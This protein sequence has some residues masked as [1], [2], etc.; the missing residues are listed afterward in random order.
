MG[1]APGVSLAQD[2]DAARIK[3]LEAE[4]ANLRLMV[5]TLESLVRTAPGTAFAQERSAAVP[6]DLGPRVVILETQIG[7]LTHQVEQIGQK[8]SALQA[9]LEAKIDAAPPPAAVGALTNQIEQMGQ[10]VSALEAK[11]KAKLDAASEP[12]APAGLGDKVDALG[13]KVSALEAQLNAAPEPAAPAGLGDQVDALGKKMRALET[14]LETT[15]KPAA[16]ESLTGQIAEL[17]KKMHTLETRL[18]AMPKAASAP[19]HAMPAPQA[20]VPKDVAPED[21]PVAAVTPAPRPTIMPE[22]AKQEAAGPEPAEPE[23][24]APEPAPVMPK[25]LTSQSA[26]TF[27]PTKP[28]WYGPRPGEADGGSPQSITPPATTGALSQSFA[29]LP[30]ENAQALY[31]QGYGDFLQRNYPAAEK[32]FSKLVKAYPNDPLAGSAQYW[33]G[34]SY[35]VREQYKKAADTFLAGYRKYSGSDK[36]PDTLLRLG[37]SLAALG[38]NNAACS[39]FKELKDKFPDAPENIRDQAKGEAGKA[40]C[41]Q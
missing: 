6:G 2:S 9:K 40:G 21:E 38:Q 13:Q 37:M 27:D 22:P 25:A 4:V 36:A 10:K 3:K 14:K 26:A 30:N 32:S 1:L 11:L 39:T 23:T 17:G 20:E 28:R 15:P 41:A 29:A 35:Y 34:E 5:G 8:V 18:D 19:A 24:T 12:A 7:A 16:I 31:E 33:A